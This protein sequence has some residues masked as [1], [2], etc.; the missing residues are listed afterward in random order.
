[1]SYLLS[2][3]DENHLTSWDGVQTFIRTRDVKELRTFGDAV[4]RAIAEDAH[5]RVSTVK[6]SLDDANFLPSASLRGASGCSHWDCRLPKIRTLARY[7]ALYCD[8]ALVPVEVRFQQKHTDHSDEVL[9]RLYLGSDILGIMEMRPLIEAGIVSI[10]P[11]QLCFCEE[12]WDKAVPEHKKIIR[13]AKQMASK[14]ASHFTVTYTP[15]EAPLGRAGFD[16]VGPE[17]YL[18]HGSIHTV[19]ESPPAWLSKRRVHGPQKLSLGTIKRQGLVLRFFLRMANDIFLQTYFGSAFNARYVTDSEGE[20]EFLKLLHERDELAMQTAAL[21]TALAHT[22]PLLTD[23][24]IDAIL[25]LRRDE[26]EAFQS[27]RSAVTGIVKKYVVSGK[28]INDSEAKEIYLDLLKPELDA[29]QAKARNVRRA[30]VKTGI[31]KLAASSALIGLGIYSGILPSQV[32]DLVK[33][34]GGLSVAKDLVETLGAI[35]RNPTEV[36][37][38][39]LYFLLRLKQEH[40]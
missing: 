7:A 34:I 27:Y 33:T 37:N 39:N 32:A 38:H 16:F 12:H 23:V 18:D 25:K 3:F 15:P 29:L 2:I 28:P 40:N 1:M 30:H 19:L 10:V 9:D 8:N 5:S 17:K 35:Q 22:V 21:C 11:E 14:N 36:R 24:P 6:P 26:P 20:A 13:T 31:L 4:R